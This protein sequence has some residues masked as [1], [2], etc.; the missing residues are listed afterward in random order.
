MRALFRRTAPRVRLLAQRRVHMGDRLEVEWSLDSPVASIE[1]VSLM[2]VGSEIARRRISA[3]T[4]ISVISE[5]R[6][7]FGTTF[8][9]VVSGG[10]G[11]RAAGGRA[12]VVVPA[13]T[14]PSLAG[15]YNE[16]AWA[17][18]VEGVLRRAPSLSE[19]YPIVVLP[20]EP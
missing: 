4:G 1:R 14:V 17:I 13:R 18:T 5:E 20:G 15:S 8:V 19:R 7:F 6:V 12:S 2:L 3:R 16:I 11:G 10:G 9:H